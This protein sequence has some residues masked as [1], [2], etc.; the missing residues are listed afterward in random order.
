M[1]TQLK[2]ARLARGWSQMRML[3]E[4]Q[5]VAMLRGLTVP[6]RTSLKTE[7]SRWEKGHVTPTEPSVGLLAEIYERSPAELGL[8]MPGSLSGALGG[9]VV[10]SPSR[11]SAESVALMEE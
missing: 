5:R 10:R 1:E 11:L 9:S 8:S 3:S 4:L 2:A 6:S 7:V